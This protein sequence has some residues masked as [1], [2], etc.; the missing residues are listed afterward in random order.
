MHL[1]RTQY[2]NCSWVQFAMDSLRPFLPINLMRRKLHSDAMNEL[3]FLQNADDFC[4][5]KHNDEMTMKRAFD[6]FRTS[7]VASRKSVDDSA[8][9]PGSGIS[10]RVLRKFTKLGVADSFAPCIALGF[11]SLLADAFL[12]EDSLVFRITVDL[13]GTNGYS[14]YNKQDAQGGWRARTSTRSLRKM[15]IIGTLFGKLILAFRQTPTSWTTSTATSLASHGISARRPSARLVRTGQLLR[16]HGYNFCGRTLA[17]PPAPRRRRQH[18]VPTTS[19]STA[20]SSTMSCSTSTD[21]MGA[22]VLVQS[23]GLPN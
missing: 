13:R 22:D 6:K 8:R 2:G 9:R 3:L 23:E 18:R 11:A 15:N 17:S 16:R 7:C 21:C 10:K 14:T 4:T 20:A 1:V 19:S 12:N 5:N